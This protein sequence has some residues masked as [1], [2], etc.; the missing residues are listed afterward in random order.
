MSVF[1]LI[2]M[3]CLL[4]ECQENIGNLT[5]ARATFDT[6]LNVLPILN[7]SNISQVL[8]RTKDCKC[9]TL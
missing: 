3:L 7:D 4:Q 9:G 6:L 2:K 8:H 1:S 5:G